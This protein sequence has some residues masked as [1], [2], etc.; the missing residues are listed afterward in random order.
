MV[1]NGFEMAIKY[2]E[3]SDTLVEIET[4]PNTKWDTIEKINKIISELNI[5]IEKDQYFTKKAE[6]ELAK[7]LKV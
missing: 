5:P 4:E 6:N 3:N 2:I 7:I 1:K